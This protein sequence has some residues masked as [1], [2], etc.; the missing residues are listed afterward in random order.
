M[1]F[2][3]SLRR[4]LSWES[5]V[6]YYRIILPPSQIGVVDNAED[7]PGETKPIFVEIS[8]DVKLPK[9]EAKPNID[10]ASVHVE[11]S[12]YVDSGVLPLQAHEV[13]T[14]RFFPNDVNSKDREELLEWARRQANR[15]GFT[16]VTQILSLI[17]PMFCLVCERSGAH[18][19]P[20][21]KNPKHAT[22]GSRKFGCLFIVTPRFPNI[23]IS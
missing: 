12:K 2:Y 16:I 18:E 8:G 11:A 9:V 17:N 1:G 23:Q 6:A 7:V 22:T 20:E 19:V 5:S 15:A 13:D 14:A 3:V 4:T 21:K 10:G